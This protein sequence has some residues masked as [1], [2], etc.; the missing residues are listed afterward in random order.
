MVLLF[1]VFASSAA[2]FSNTLNH[3]FLTFCIQM[4]FLVTKLQD[5]KVCELHR[6]DVEL[7]EVATK[8]AHH[9]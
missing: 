5:L 1:F 9:G 3:I 4:C 6:T 2:D 8:R 7:C